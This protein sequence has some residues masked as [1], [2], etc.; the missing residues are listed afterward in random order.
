[1]G[2]Y[3]V[4]ELQKIAVEYIDKAAH[5]SFEEGTAL[6]NRI[7]KGP[8]D[9]TNEIGI[10]VNIYV[11]PNASEGWISE[12]GDYPVADADVS[13]NLAVKYKAAFKTGSMTLHAKVQQDANLMWDP[14]KKSVSR[15]ISG[16]KK[17]INGHMFLDGSGAI[18]VLSAAYSGGTPTVITCGSTRSTQ[19][20]QKLEKRKRVQIYDTTGVTPRTGGGANVLAVSSRSLS[21]R[22]AT[23]TSNVPTDAVD[24]DIVVPEGSVNNVMKGLNF[25]ISTSGSYFGQSRT[26]YPGLK[27]NE[28][29]ASS[30]AGSISLMDQVF[31]VMVYRIGS[32]MDESTADDLELWWS[33]AQ[34][35]NYRNQGF[36][37]KAFTGGKNETLDLGFPRRE[38]T[39]SGYKTNVDVDCQDDK[40]WYVRA[41]KLKM[42]ELMPP[43]VIDLG[44]GLLIPQTAASG[45][46]YSSKFIFHLGYF[47]E[48]YSPEPYC[49]G[50]LDNLDV[51]NLPSGNA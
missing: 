13:V 25:I 1:L 23:F 24:T 14:V 34:R 5:L 38:E 46:G 39:V 10:R 41:S 48:F 33:P 47:G 7:G 31:N 21:S 16:L 32:D 18:A 6:L 37:L 22:T 36:A 51:T 2:D 17:I 43:K 8:K 15:A 45:Q 11:E 30:A 26:T 19:G 42:A 40:I 35:Q 27:A 12:G 28:T 44:T 3:N 4:A 50:V 9:P 49:L 29:D 20:T